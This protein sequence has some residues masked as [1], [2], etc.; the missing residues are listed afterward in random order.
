MWK[1]AYEICVDLMRAIHVFNAH[2]APFEEAHEYV[3]LN[4]N[5]NKFA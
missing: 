1:R 3:C 5:T 4:A 2:Q